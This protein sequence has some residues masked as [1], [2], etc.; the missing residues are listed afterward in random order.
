M[1]IDSPDPTWPSW[2]EVGNSRFELRYEQRRHNQ[3]EVYEG[4]QAN[5]WMIT[6][7]EGKQVKTSGTGPLDAAKSLAFEI[8]KALGAPGDRFGLEM[9]LHGR[10][11]RNW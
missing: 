7:V 1:E 3:Y 4:S 2:I 10:P 5:W 8:K 11:D 6:E 9:H